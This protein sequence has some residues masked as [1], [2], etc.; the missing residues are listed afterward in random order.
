[1]KTR[2]ALLCMALAGVHAAQAQPSAA[3]RASAAQSTAETS[4]KC[5][6]VQPFYWS[7]GDARGVLADGRAGARAP[8]AATQMPIA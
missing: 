7:I 5:R 1:M 2:L 8:T 4:D 3:Q 6:A